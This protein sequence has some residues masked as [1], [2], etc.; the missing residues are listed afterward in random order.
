MGGKEKIT[1]SL[2]GCK[3][4]AGE[5]LI[6]GRRKRGGKESHFYIEEKEGRRGK[7]ALEGGGR[8]G[9][10][11]TGGGEGGEGKGGG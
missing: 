10:G 4:N 6:P 2:P 9:G 11:G 5:S 8:G 3:R 1:A 7:E